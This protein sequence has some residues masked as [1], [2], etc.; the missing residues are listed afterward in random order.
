VAGSFEHGK[1]SDFLKCEDSLYQSCDSRTLLHG[2]GSYTNWGCKEI[3]EYAFISRRIII[4]HLLCIVTALTT[5][6]G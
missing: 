4:V 2:T 3:A 6:S 1:P 5:E